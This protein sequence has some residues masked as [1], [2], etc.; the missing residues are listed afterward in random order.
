MLVTIPVTLGTALC[1]SVILQQITKG[2]KIFP[3]LFSLSNHHA[4]RIYSFSHPVFSKIMV[5]ESDT[6][7]FYLPEKDWLHTS[8]AFGSSVFYISGNL[9]DI[10]FSFIL[11]DFR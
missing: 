1:I 3:T 5:F 6:K 4:N 2:Q 11:P 7:L 9:L 8:S 10:I